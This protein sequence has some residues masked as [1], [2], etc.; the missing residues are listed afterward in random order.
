[1]DQEPK[2]SQPTRR[3]LLAG[4]GLGMIGI[5]ATAAPGLAVAAGRGR[6]GSSPQAGGN[7]QRGDI[8]DW[9]GYVG[10]T[11]D[12]SPGSG[13][14]LRLVAVEPMASGGPRPAGVR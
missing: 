4:L 2:G 13:S 6:K 11:F 3:N 8:A 9:T 12:L 14:A 7:L 1:M 5:A 10:K